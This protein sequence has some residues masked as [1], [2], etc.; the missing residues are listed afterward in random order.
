[1]INRLCGLSLPEWL[2]EAGAVKI[3]TQANIRRT[4]LST[5][6]S[7]AV[8]TRSSML[9]SSLIRHLMAIRLWT[10]REHLLKHHAGQ[11]TG[12]VFLARSRQAAIPT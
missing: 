8:K 11:R 10:Y 12:M 7:K 2:T 4:A 9:K 3:E 1:M 6:R 5:S